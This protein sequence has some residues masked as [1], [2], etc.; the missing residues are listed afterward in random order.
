[1][2]PTII[3]VPG[4]TQ[5]PIFYQPFIEALQ[6]EGFSAKVVS[7][8]STGADH[9]METFDED[10]TA[11]Q[12]TVVGVLEEG[13]EVVVVMHSYGGIPGSAAMRDLGKAQRTK[14]GKAGGV[15]RLVYAASFLLREGDAMPGKGD[16]ESMRAGSVI[17]EKVS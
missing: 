8:P 4:A 11:V 1:M 16:Y 2:S 15:V 10:V 12:R 3:V 9:M 17:D 7:L 13:L 14:A 5:P 6:K